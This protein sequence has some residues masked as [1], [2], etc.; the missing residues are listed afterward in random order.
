M[1]KVLITGANGLL[2]QHLV[3]QLLQSNYEVIATGKGEQRIVIKDNP[4]F[5]YHKVDITE[6]FELNKI[7]KRERPD[8]VV[9]A[10][11]M[12]QI[13]DC[14]QQPEL[15]EKVNVQGTAQVLYDAEAYCK[16]FIYVSTDFV[17]DGVK[18]NYKETDELNPVSFYGFTKMQAESMV[19][20]S[21]IPWAIVRT[22]LVY[23]NTIEGTRSNIVSWVKNSLQEGKKIKVVCDQV[24]TP[25]FVEDL[26]K[27]I[28]LVIAKRATGIYHISGRDVL[29]P[30]DMALH[31]AEC[32][33]L[34][35]NLIE[36]TDASSFKQPAKR[37][38]KTGFNISKACTE[39]G[40][41]P[42]GF[43]EAIQKV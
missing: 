32:F 29:T 16:H 13:D 39:L 25:T 8:A 43:C 19:E 37:P 27:G 5:T 40:F 24:R 12:T 1:K 18:G 14:E 10:A 6:G 21:E 17:F 34:D 41:E 11:A 3:K 36:K 22:C 26:A 9:H 30:Y 15:C 2:G 35:K 28:E 20:A 31:T 4:F 23:G 33:N 42:I 38:P 7:L